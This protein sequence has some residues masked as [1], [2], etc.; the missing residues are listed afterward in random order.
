MEAGR[1]DPWQRTSLPWRAVIVVSVAAVIVW[2]S[3]PF[4]SG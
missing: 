3:W 2:V 4:V 1:F